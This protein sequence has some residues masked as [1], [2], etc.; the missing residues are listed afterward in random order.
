VF[1]LAR[2]NAPLTTGVWQVKVKPFRPVI[3]TQKVYAAV[4]TCR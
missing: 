2:V 3:G 4:S 1:E